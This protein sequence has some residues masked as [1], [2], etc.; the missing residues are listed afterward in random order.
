MG[1]DTAGTGCWKTPRGARTQ[2]L[3]CSEGAP[4]L[5]QWAACLLL[6]T[7]SVLSS[8]DSLSLPEPPQTAQEITGG[9]RLGRGWSTL[10][11]VTPGLDPVT[12]EPGSQEG[13]SH[14]SREAAGIQMDRETKAL[15]ICRA[16]CTVSGPMEVVLAL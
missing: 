10:L 11:P 15:S 13:E 2:L 4:R 3:C 16:L 1:H 7:A 12:S 9:A 14:L 6:G 8:C 5:G